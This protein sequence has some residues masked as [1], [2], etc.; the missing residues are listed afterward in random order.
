[1]VSGTIISHAGVSVTWL[2]DHNLTVDTINETFKVNTKICNWSGDN[3]YGDDVTQSPLWIRPRSLLSDLPVGW[4]QIVGHT[5]QKDI[6]TIGRV[7][8]VDCLDT[9]DKIYEF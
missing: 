8:F 1:M 6:T 4:E 3:M 5:H 9:V 7:T 2:R